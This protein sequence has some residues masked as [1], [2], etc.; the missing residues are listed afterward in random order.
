[1]T[2]REFTIANEFQYDTRSPL[3]WLSVAVICVGVI[4]LSRS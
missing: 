4:L 3:R 1:M 2:R